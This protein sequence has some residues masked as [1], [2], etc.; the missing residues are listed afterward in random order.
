MKQLFDVRVDVIF[1]HFR[2]S[3]GQTDFVLIIDEYQA[4]ASVQAT[5]QQRVG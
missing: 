4:K 3:D 2:S 5:C 1:T